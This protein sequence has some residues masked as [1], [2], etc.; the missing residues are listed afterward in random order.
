MTRI[1]LIGGP[2]HGQTVD[3]PFQPGPLVRQAGDDGRQYFYR[4]GGSDAETGAHRYHLAGLTHW[5]RDTWVV[6]GDDG[7][8]PH[9]P[10]RNTL[11]TQGGEL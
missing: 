10:Y 11:A 1:Q 8:T 9:T 4:R 3:T 7:H 6:L 5:R 2:W